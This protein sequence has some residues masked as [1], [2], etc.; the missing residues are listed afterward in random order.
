METEN[1]QIAIG[2]VDVQTFE[3]YDYIHH[4]GDKCKFEI[5]KSGQ[6]ILSLE[7]DGDFFRVCKN[8]S[9]LDEETIHLISEKIESY[10]L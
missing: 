2:K 10:Y 1:F 9:E 8:P 3:V 5:Y 6:L 7:P 4:E